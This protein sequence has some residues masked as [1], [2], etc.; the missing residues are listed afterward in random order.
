MQYTLNSY[1]DIL[2]SGYDYSLPEH[3]IS[4]I[5]KLVSDL[6]VPL[7][8]QRP[9]QDDNEF[10]YKKSGTNVR[11][12]R[13]SNKKDNLEDS[14]KSAIPFKSTHIDK[15]EGI[16]KTIN[17]IRV[18]LNKISNKNYELQRDSIFKLITDIGTEDLQGLNMVSQALFDIATTNKFYSELYATLYKE[19]CVNFAIFETIVKNVIVDYLNS[20][21]LIEFVDSNSDYDKYC[22]NNKKND[23][24]KAMTTFIVYLMKKEIIMK[25]E[26]LEVISNLLLKTILYI[27]EENKLVEVEEITE[28]IFIFITLSICDLKT[29][30]GWTDVVKSIIICSQCKA[31]DHLSISSRAIFK[32]MDILDYIKKQ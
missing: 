17:D 9:V 26:L 6:G 30:D 11:K 31:K 7:T 32:Y 10:K 14:W 2:F 25:K 15:K 24:R 5:N 18:C 19:L 4:V 8:E 27:D 20:I 1:S 13:S 29:E 23:K 3:I 12:N 21:E 28:N 22:D 16:E